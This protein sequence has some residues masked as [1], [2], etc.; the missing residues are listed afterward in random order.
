[1]RVV[2]YRTI[3]AFCFILC[4]A[5]TL[6]LYLLGVPRFRLVSTIVVLFVSQCLR[7]GTVQHIQ[8]ANLVPRVSTMGILM[9][10]DLIVLGFDSLSL[11][12][13]LGSIVYDNFPNGYLLDW[14]SYRGSA[15]SLS[16]NQKKAVMMLRSFTVLKILLQTC[17]ICKVPL[18]ADVASLVYVLM[19]RVALN[20]VP[21]KLAV[22]VSQQL[23]MSRNSVSLIDDQSLLTKDTRL[24]TMYAYFALH[25]AGYNGFSV[26]DVLL[27]S[28]PYEE[29]YVEYR[30][31]L[32]Y[33][34][35]FSSNMRHLTPLIAR[36]ELGSDGKAGGATS[37]GANHSLTAR[38]KYLLNAERLA[39]E[40]S[41]RY[42]K[43][44]LGVGRFSALFPSG[45]EA[46][47]VL[48]KLKV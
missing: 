12:L 34:L 44:N 47:A 37:N 6:L 36:V 35:R 43:D 32:L 38:A 11:L 33:A 16:A 24:P 40:D 17:V 15:V 14:T 13:V 28:I 3:I 19:N 42:V 27:T 46:M 39:A 25:S 18:H 7:C 31:M 8:D 4:A 23:G 1:M 21:T 20:V 22:W 5:A 48:D 41:L 45:V 30:H 10:I 9:V 29:R 26:P 2:I